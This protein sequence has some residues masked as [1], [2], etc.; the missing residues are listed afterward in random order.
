MHIHIENDKA[1]QVETCAC[2]LSRLLIG[3]SLRKSIQIVKFWEFLLCGS[4][5]TIA[6]ISQSWDYVALFVELFV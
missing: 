2:V 4:V 6:S 3:R 5:E 1:A